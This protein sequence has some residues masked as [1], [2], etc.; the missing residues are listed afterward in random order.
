LNLNLGCGYRKRDGWVNVDAAPACDPDVILDIEKLPWP[1]P[2]D[3]VERVAFIHSLEHMGRDPAVF[4]GIMKE[5]YRVCRNGAE[6][7]IVVPHPRHDNFLGDPTHVRIITPHMLEHFNREQC[8]RIKREGGSNTPFAHYLDVDF[9]VASTSK[10]LDE[11]YFTQYRE[12]KLSGADLERM[13]REL[14]NVVAQYEIVL[15][16]RKQGTTR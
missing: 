2:D 8:D 16:A 14:N 5:L 3:S 6:I 1:W 7:E 11:P 10:S 4:L 13:E 15:I 12:G 9:I